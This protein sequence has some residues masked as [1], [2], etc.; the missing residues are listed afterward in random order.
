MS[1]GPKSKLKIQDNGAQPAKK[2]DDL[3][4]VPNS[5][6]SHWLFIPCVEVFF[7]G[8]HDNW[9]EKGIA[10]WSQYTLNKLCK[11]DVSSLLNREL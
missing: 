8:V 3:K 6:E 1:F 7:G 5:N 11:I 10:C 9:H 2:E 4:V